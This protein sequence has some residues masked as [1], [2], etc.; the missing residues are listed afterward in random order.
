MVRV[1]ERF[2]LS[3]PCS[4]PMQIMAHTNMHTFVVLAGIHSIRV[5]SWRTTPPMFEAGG[6]TPNHQ[7]QTYK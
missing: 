7:L 1:L 5:A 6:Q 4:T 2:G 3:H